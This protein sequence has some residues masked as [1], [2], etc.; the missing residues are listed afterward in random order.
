[1]KKIILSLIFILCF[2]VIN[3]QYI[4]NDDHNAICKIQTL[5]EKTFDFYRGGIK[6]ASVKNDILY[7]GSGTK[8]GGVQGKVLYDDSGNV[9]CTIEKKA[10]YSGGK[11]VAYVMNDIVYDAAGIRVVA[12]SGIT[13]MQIAIYIFFIAN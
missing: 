2:G 9:I 6:L 12:V 4:F 5:D 3:A 10:I 7:D 1:M 8:I 11:K 13:I